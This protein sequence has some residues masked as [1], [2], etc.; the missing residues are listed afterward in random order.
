MNKQRSGIKYM[1]FISIFA[2]LSY[3]AFAFLQ[4]KIWLP[5]GDATSIHFGNAVCVLASLLM[6]GVTGGLA[7]AVGMTVGDLFDPVYVIY[8]PKTFLCKLCMGLVTGFTAH[9]VLHINEVK[10]KKKLLKYAVVS[11]AAGLGFN[12]IF[13]PL[14]GFFYKMVILGTPMAQISLVWNVGA[15]SIN[16]V[17]SVIAASLIYVKLKPYFEHHG[18]GNIAVK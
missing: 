18:F 11:T 2:A 6:D 15:T 10:D 4:F 7:G 17:I 9:K 16:A 5:G 1:A 8:A 12:V 3:V 13:D 14:L